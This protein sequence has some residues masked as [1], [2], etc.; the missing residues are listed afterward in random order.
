MVTFYVNVFSYFSIESSPSEYPQHS[1]VW[2]Q[3]FNT[4]EHNE[5][6]KLL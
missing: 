5:Y 6:N 2:C 4:S 3:F 1:L